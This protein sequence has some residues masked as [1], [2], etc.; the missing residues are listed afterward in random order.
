[1]VVKARYWLPDGLLIRFYIGLN[2]LATKP[3]A[4]LIPE[5]DD[6]EQW[7]AQK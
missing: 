3:R 4:K 7:I 1:M 6:L 2:N 5:V